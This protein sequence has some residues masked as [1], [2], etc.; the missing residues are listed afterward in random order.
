MK[1]RPIRHFDFYVGTMVD[2]LTDEKDHCVMD[3]LGQHIRHMGG[4]SMR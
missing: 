1:M 4:E 3:K 2:I